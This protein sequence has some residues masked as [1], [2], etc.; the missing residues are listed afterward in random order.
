MWNWPNVTERQ[1]DSIFFYLQLKSKSA[2]HQRGSITKKGLTKQIT[3]VQH[4]ESKQPETEPKVP[5]N[6][7]C[8]TSAAD[9]APRHIPKH[10]FV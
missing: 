8:L 7:V 3:T 9:N 10:W 5:T 1:R 6:Q 4:L 2:S